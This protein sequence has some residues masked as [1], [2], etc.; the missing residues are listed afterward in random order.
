[1]HFVSLTWLDEGPRHRHGQS[2]THCEPHNPN[3]EGSKEYLVVHEVD[4]MP[5]T[6]ERL[7]RWHI[8]VAFVRRLVLSFTRERRPEVRGA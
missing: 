2:V 4:K 3:A 5:S 8:A 6:G 7:M 1:M